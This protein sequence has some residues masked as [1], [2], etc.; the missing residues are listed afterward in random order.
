MK[1]LISLVALMAIVI[2]SGCEKDEDIVRDYYQENDAWYSLVSTD[3]L[4]CGDIY[5][6]YSGF[7]IRKNYKIVRAVFQYHSNDGTQQ[8]TL[9]GCACWPLGKN[10][11]KEIWLENLITV[12]RWDECPSQDLSPT[13]L[14]CHIRNAL[15]VGPDRQGY[16]LTRDLPIPYFATT[17][18]ATQSADCM[19]AAMHLFHDQGF[20]LTDDYGTYV[21][22]A[23]LG[24]AI[25]LAF[26]R[27]VE[28]DKELDNL[29]HLTK[30]YCADGPYDQQAM[31]HA[32]LDQPTEK[33]SYPL[34]FFCSTKSILCTEKDL[35][36]KYSLSDIFTERVIQS[37]IIE[38][39]DSKQL[40]TV[41]LNKILTD[42]EL[43]TPQAILTEEYLDINS[44]IRKDFE[45]AF[46]KL[47]LITGWNPQKEIVFYHSDMDEVVPISCMY[48]VQENM[49]GSN[50][51]FNE[52]KG[53]NHFDACKQFYASMVLLAR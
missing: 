4:D 29:I 49:S 34:L 21:M 30:T 19:K 5:E 43:E 41:Q 13:F 52:I 32:L 39:L 20:R 53:L 48:S 25:S 51:S 44:T 1:R 10:D 12:T 23:S 28:S 15:Y 42:L 36:S 17:L 40:T 22:G 26:D 8:L 6:F 33:C 9:S 3:T 2:F 45:K 14:L 46:V 24:G 31:Y 11:F 7:P 27:I 37:G 35:A 18:F 47:N 38:K 50:L 16:G